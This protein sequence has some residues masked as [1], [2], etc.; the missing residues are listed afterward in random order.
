M[1]LSNS[2]LF[3]SLTAVINTSAAGEEETCQMWVM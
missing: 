3:D 2:K 1:N